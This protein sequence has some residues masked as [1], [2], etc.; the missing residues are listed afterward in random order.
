MRKKYP[1]FKIYGKNHW[2]FYFWKPSS[3]A[4]LG[5]VDETRPLSSQF[6]SKLDLYRHHEADIAAI[7]MQ[8]SSYDSMFVSKCQNSSHETRSMH[9][10]SILQH[11]CQ[12]ETP[13]LC[14]F[15]LKPRHHTNN[16]Q[17]V[18]FHLFSYRFLLQQLSCNVIVK[19]PTKTTV[20]KTLFFSFQSSSNFSVLVAHGDT[21]LSSLLLCN[22]LEIC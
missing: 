21:K 1:L 18:N 20:N 4:L 13:K 2:E 22:I 15:Y 10:L 8:K 12:S 11:Q 19:N 5:S 6:V 3:P 7:V 16:E 9:C 14:L 17:L